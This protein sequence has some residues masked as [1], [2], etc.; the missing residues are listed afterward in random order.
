MGVAVGSELT[1]CRHYG[2]AWAI[3][4]NDS[5]WGWSCGMMMSVRRRSICSFVASFSRA[6]FASTAVMTR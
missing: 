6:A 2:M 3:R 5:L 4:A 1:F